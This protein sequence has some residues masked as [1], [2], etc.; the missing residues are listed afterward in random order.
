M[1][2]KRCYVCLLLCDMTV[3]LYGLQAASGSVEAHT[4]ISFGVEFD[5]DM[6]CAVDE[7]ERDYVLKEVNSCDVVTETAEGTNQD[8][9][10]HRKEK[11]SR[12]RA[13]LKP[14]SSYRKTHELDVGS[15]CIKSKSAKD[16]MSLTVIK[17]HGS[18]NVALSAHEE[19]NDQDVVCSWNSPLL[20]STP[21]VVDLKRRVADED[22]T[23]RNI[24]S[25]AV[26]AAD[27]PGSEMTVTPKRLIS[28]RKSKTKKAEKTKLFEV[29]LNNSL[30]AISHTES[31]C[32]QSGHQ[33]SGRSNIDGSPS[34][35]RE[36]SDAHVTLKADSKLWLVMV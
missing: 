5:D 18:E 31:A 27:A 7:L 2:N 24:A 13:N 6:I 16:A 30:N 15:Q 28:G 19:A 21:M 9:C 25:D 4:N 17:G 12:R 20:V 33:S 34:D 22:I 3:V 11:I 14:G 10:C 8:V 35:R 23:K 32:L 1:T 29:I 26:M 36:T